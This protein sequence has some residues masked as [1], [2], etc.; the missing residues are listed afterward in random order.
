MRERFQF[1]S[2][3]LQDARGDFYALPGKN[4][5]VAV[6]FATKKMKDGYRVEA[7]FVDGATSFERKTRNR[8]C[9]RRSGFTSAP[10]RRARQAAVARNGG[11]RPIAQGDVH[12]SRG[13][14]RRPS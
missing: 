6:S 12:A 2:D 5:E 4:R 10:I 13:G 9:P 8:T 1:I 14:D 3:A 11:P 7:V